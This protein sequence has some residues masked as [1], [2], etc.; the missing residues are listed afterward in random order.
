M[1]RHNQ[2]HV[3]QP[4]YIAPVVIKSIAKNRPFPMG[5]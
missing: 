1:H 5:S 2:G 3:V 4:C